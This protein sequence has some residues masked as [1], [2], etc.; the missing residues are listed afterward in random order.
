MAY[1][2]IPA[3]HVKDLNNKYKTVTDTLAKPG[4]KEETLR[5]AGL[6]KLYLEDI[7]DSLTDD[8]AQL[9]T[10]FGLHQKNIDNIIKA[11]QVDLKYAR[12]ITAKY[13]SKQYPEYPDQ[14][15]HVAAKLVKAVNTAQ[16]DA[17]DFGDAWKGYRENVAKDVPPA[18]YAAAEAVR[19]R[20]IN[21]S[22]ITAAKI[23]QLKAAANEAET[24]LG[25]V[26][27]A[28]RKRVT[29]VDQPL[30]EAQRAAAAVSKKLAD[31]LDEARNPPGRG[32]QPNSIKT[33]SEYLVQGAADK[34]LTDVPSN[35]S[36]N[37]G[38]WANV[39][40]SWKGL[41]TRALSME[42]VLSDSKKGFRSTEL[43]DPLV[44]AEMAKAA[45][46]VAAVKADV[47][48]YAGHYTKAKAAIAKIK[49]AYAAKKKK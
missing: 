8:M 28:T 40:A 35:L 23:V 22:K 12:Q 41:N 48:L 24:L 18:T 2:A 27:K 34:K 15:R 42:K 30:A 3:D 16:Q 47:K 26:G 38:R 11:S 7:K 21:D 20:I 32:T 33:N 45:V 49:A 44:K 29:G 36:N 5:L 17:L 14:V 9:T 31:L 13:K 1:T 4:T 6:Q 37:E 43:A 25:I 39:E 46:S 19:K 10:N